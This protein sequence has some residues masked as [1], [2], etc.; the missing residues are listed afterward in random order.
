M[1]SPLFLSYRNK[2]R[3]ALS[4]FLSWYAQEAEITKAER[5][6]GLPELFG[7]DA[8]VIDTKDNLWAIHCI[9]RLIRE[10]SGRS[11]RFYLDQ[12]KRWNE[13]QL[14]LLELE[15]FRQKRNTFSL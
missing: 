4:C 14:F 5:E 2:E 7:S 10:T 9:D 11:F 15:V 3:S 6:R 13:E 8:D 1:I 12:W